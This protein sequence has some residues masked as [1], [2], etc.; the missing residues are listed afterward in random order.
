[1]MISPAKHGDLSKRNGAETVECETELVKQEGLR[2]T[3]V[4]ECSTGRVA[5]PPTRTEYKDLMLA[6]TMVDVCR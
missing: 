3:Y 4:I 1:M 2:T 5:Q 6:Q